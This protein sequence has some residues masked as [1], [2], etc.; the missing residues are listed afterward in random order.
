MTV[1]IF[2]NFHPSDAKY[3]PIEGHFYVY[4]E[5]DFGSLNLSDTGKIPYL[6]ESYITVKHQ[7]EWKFIPLGS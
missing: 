1:I 7:L 5:T 6:K 2:L 3:L 4:G